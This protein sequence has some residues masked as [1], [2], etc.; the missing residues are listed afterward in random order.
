MK[1]RELVDFLLKNRKHELFLTTYVIIYT[2]MFEFAEAVVPTSGYAVSYLKIDD[3]IPFCEEFIIFYGAWFVFLGATGLYAIV[4]EPMAYRRFMY[5]MMIGYTSAVL[6]FLL[7][8]NGQD[9]RPTVFPDSNIFTWLVG[10][11]YSVDTNTNVF[12]SIHVIGAVQ[13]MLVYFDAHSLKP[14]RWW[15]VGLTVLIIFSTVFVK[16]HS[17]LDMFGGLLWCV[18][19]AIAVYGEKG[20]YSSRLQKNRRAFR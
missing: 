15:A 5:F 13:A 10:F 1:I 6:F 19:C 11:A 20:V 4:R 14:Y 12:P 9:L 3:Y 2:L 17:I 16:Q 7:F 18:P 8:P